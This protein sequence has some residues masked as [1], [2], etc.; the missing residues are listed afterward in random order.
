M[1]NNMISE[2]RNKHLM[3][4]VTSQNLTNTL[5]IY[6]V[7]KFIKHLCKGS[8]DIQIGRCINKYLIKN[9][10]ILINSVSKFLIII[11]CIII[12]MR[13]IYGYLKGMMDKFHIP[14]GKIIFTIRRF[15]FRLPSRKDIQ[16]R[17]EFP[18]INLST[19]ELKLLVEKICS[20]AR[21]R[22]A[23]MADT[24]LIDE[25]YS[26]L[27]RTDGPYFKHT[28][29]HKY[30]GF[31]P[32]MGKGLDDKCMVK[33]L[34]RTTADGIQNPQLDSFRGFLP[35][36]A[37]LIDFL[38]TTMQRCDDWKY[39]HREQ[40]EFIQHNRGLTLDILEQ[41]EV[42]EIVA[43]V[44]SESELVETVSW[45]WDHYSRDQKICPTVVVSM[46]VE[47][48]QCT[49]Y[50][51]YKMSGWMK[52]TP[53]QVLST[54]PGPG[55]EDE[56]EDRPV[57][58]PVKIMIGN[59][60]DHALMISLGL[61]LNHKNQYLVTRLEIQDSLLDFLAKLPIC[62]GMSV[63]HDIRD[64]EF[65]YSM[66]SGKDLIMKGFV[67]LV[68]IALLA[69]YQMKSRSMSPFSVQ[70][71]GTTM[72]K[73]VSTGD[74]K[75]G[76]AWK[77]VP[78]ALKIYALGDIRLGHIAYMVLA[79][80]IL[81]DFFPDPDICLQYF[82]E[83]E[84][85]PV[86]EWFMRLITKS[87]DGAEVH[88]EDFKKAMTRV[89]LIRCIRFRFGEGCPLMSEPPPRVEM[90]CSLLGD[91]PTVTKGG[92]RFI[93]QARIW[94]MQ[95]V[96]VFVANKFRGKDGKIVPEIKNRTGLYSG[97]G[98]EKEILEVTNFEEKVPGA[99]GLLRPKSL[100]AKP[101]IM[102]PDTVKCQFIGKF[103]K[104]QSRNLTQILL[105]WARSNPNRIAEF[106]RRMGQERDF[107][108][109]FRHVY[110][111]MRHIFRRIH[112]CEALTVVF[113]DQELEGRL[114]STYAE[115][116]ER[117][118]MILQEAQIREDRLKFMKQRLESG[119]NEERS[120][121]Q[122]EIPAMPAWVIRRNRRLRKRE[123]SLT[124]KGGEEKRSRL[125][126]EQDGVPGESMEKR[127]DGTRDEDVVTEKTH[128]KDA[129]NHGS[130]IED[131]EEVIVMIDE[132]DEIVVSAGDNIL[133]DL[134]AP[135]VH[136][137]KI[138]PR[139]WKKGKKKVSKIKAPERSYTYDEIIESRIPYFED[140]EF[141][142]EFS[143]NEKF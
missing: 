113:I 102:N 45:F 8:N 139:K 123:R 65:Y 34:S 87:L 36:G 107:Q 118:Q 90:W 68:T 47:E 71:T 48:I 138:I 25:F 51:V 57:N 2:Y 15:H 11:C 18:F 58:I 4:K 20:K 16:R 1:K 67:D 140:E 98:I 44:T 85:W 112:D 143:C 35:A 75:W 100:K 126:Q 109:F 122:E 108:R 9:R 110:D 77:D 136:D 53:G 73:C 40:I 13:K 27:W 95:Q 50:D 106:L 111:P 116:F 12:R 41:V 60:L 121:W 104:K 131:V 62:T 55:V 142:L 66:L 78:D 114:E 3:P 89:E 46:D 43:G 82:S 63:K 70:I 19:G 64:I 134:D 86:V 72:N 59:G 52:F 80:V 61:D 49:L 93:I 7:Y 42:R 117:H 105:E 21:S 133:G 120:R 31:Y 103:C 137:K 38:A 84:Q 115:E 96:K 94:F 130:E 22:P 33:F 97:F 88:E 14:L 69:G 119:D 83:F 23:T 101:L 10:R 141:D 26:D 91:W 132:D 74:S 29:M 127:P 129:S 92:C 99:V 28:L 128:E 56:A 79:G 76:R 124:P 6:L 135:V 54:K 17:M 24:I 37:P 32:I 30:V 125:D 81:R 39:P 5:F